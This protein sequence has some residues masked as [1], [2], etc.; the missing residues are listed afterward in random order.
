MLDPQESH[1]ADFATLLTFRW[2]LEE[3]EGSAGR[4]TEYGESAGGS[5]ASRAGDESAATGLG[6]C[7]RSV[8]VRDV[9]VDEPR[10]G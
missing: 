1:E 10:R 7:D 2:M 9:D 6:F 3:R 4:V 5:F 8:E